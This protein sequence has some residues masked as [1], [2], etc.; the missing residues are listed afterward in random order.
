MADLQFPVGI[1]NFSEIRTKGYYYIDKTNLVAE[2]LDGGIP[3]VNLITRPRR[4]GKSLGMSTLANFL[5]ITKDSKQMFEGLAISKNTELCKK[6]MNQC[7]VVFFSFKDTDGLTFESAYGMLCMKLAFAF[8]D[9]QFLLDDD[10][11][12]DDDKGIFKRILGR[13]A[14]MDETKS[15][16]LLL[17]RM[18]EIHFKKSAVVIL[19]EYDVPIAK[20]SSNGYYS[21]M[22]D[23]MRA[24][25]S[26]TLKD[27]TSLDFAVVTGCLKIAKESIFT[28]T[29]NF[30]S[31]TILSPRL[32][33]S[34]GFT[35]A[36]VDQ[37]LKDAGLESQ[38]AEI[39]AWYDGYHFGDADIY[40]PWD[41]ISY[42]RDFQYGVAQKPKSYWKNTS[43]NAIIRSF[44]DYAGDNIT[45]KLETLMA[46]GSIVQHIEE[47]LTY[48]YL[49][50][51][52][53]NLWS[54]LYLTGYLTKVRD[55]DLTDSLPDGCSA[56]MIPNAEIREIFETTVSKWF[57]DSAK[58][59]NR[60]PLFDAVWSVNNEA[61]TKEMTKLLRMTISYHDYREDFYHAFLAGIFRSEKPA[62]VGE[63]EM[64]STIAD[65]AQEKGALLQRRGVEW[66]YSVTDHDW[67][68]SDAHGTLENLPLPLVPQPNAATAL[69]ALRASGLE[70]SE[71]AIRDGIASAILPGRFQI[72]SESP[73]VIFDVAHNPHA[74]EYLTG[75]MKALPKNGRVL[76]VIG[77]LHDK[78]I[79]GTL[80]WLKS[81]VDDWYCAPLEGPRGATAEQLLEHLG[82]GKS[83][84]SVAQ[85]WD[86]A[87]ADAKA[88]DT[89]LVCG[90]FHTVA[91]V[92][93]VI[94]ARRSGG[95]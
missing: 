10:A 45:T 53:E 79:A 37:M 86:A 68:F 58:A 40:C 85:A 30:V 81:V 34:F 33:E 15:C 8:Q 77:M 50:S 54:V 59:W 64:P 14:S 27:N 52:E 12:S 26:T 75:R 66:N 1:S 42:L 16:F 20:A 5:D 48:D 22:L 44:I 83:F 57:D 3:K 25:M 49:H 80:A 71:N 82:N 2:I 95:K 55:K 28:G 62:I 56:L 89:V 63:P 93:E 23:V 88:E 47:N 38:S 36:D 91:H 18:L 31:D 70:V 21:Q 13:T 39:K 61:L 51:S 19:D 92:M 9:Y 73:R 32:S 72:V 6:W 41:V 17:T 87:M 43:D 46:G 24:M 94:D 84:D 69:A 67:A 35:Q 76:A 29:N 4:F 65:V 7:P 74:A 78:D 60:S 90:S 11:I